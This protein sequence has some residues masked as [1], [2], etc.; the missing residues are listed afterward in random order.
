MCPEISKSERIN[1]EDK[2]FFYYVANC[3]AINIKCID[4]QNKCSLCL[5]LP[6]VVFFCKCVLLAAYFR[7][8]SVLCLCV[9]VYVIK[10]SLFCLE[11]FR[12]KNDLGVTCPG[13]VLK[14]KVWVGVQSVLTCP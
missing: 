11:T 6:K 5:D 10:H 4:M 14:T 9:C 8:C 1:T 2:E 13:N 3:Q 7:P 12:K